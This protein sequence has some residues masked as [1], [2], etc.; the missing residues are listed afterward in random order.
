MKLISYAFSLLFGRRYN[1]LTSAASAAR[2]TAMPFGLLNSVFRIDQSQ[3]N[4]DF[5]KALL[6]SWLHWLRC[7]TVCIALSAT[8]LL[9]I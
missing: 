5:Y 7:R 2:P 6:G 9:I 3:V 1:A 4:A 8:S